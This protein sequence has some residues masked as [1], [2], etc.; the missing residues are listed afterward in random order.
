METLETLGENL[1]DFTTASDLDAW[2][3]RR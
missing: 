3:A 2:L 1:L